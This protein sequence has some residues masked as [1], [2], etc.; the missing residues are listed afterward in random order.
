[1][2]IPRVYADTSVFGGAF[3]EEFATPSRRFFD[4]VR[5]G[6]FHLVISALVEEELAAAPPQVRELY[7]EMLA[8]A[9]VVGITEEATELRQ[10]HLHAGIVTPRAFADALHVAL[11]STAGC[12]IIV[13]WNFRHIVNFRRIP[14]YNAV[15]AVRWY[16]QMAIHSPFEVI[17]VEDEDI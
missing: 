10:A 12:A 9:E 16:R 7:D 11:A 2:R 3:D 1:M 6:W 4:Q 5:A 13:S 15:N 17:A 8:L 14:L